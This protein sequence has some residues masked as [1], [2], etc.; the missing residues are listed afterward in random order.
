[1]TAKLHRQITSVLRNLRTAHSVG[2]PHE[3]HLHW[4]HLEDL[5]DRAARHG[6]DATVWVIRSTLPPR[7]WSPP[8]P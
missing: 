7:V 5:L 1:V 8:R 3:V 2:L 4:R 6:I